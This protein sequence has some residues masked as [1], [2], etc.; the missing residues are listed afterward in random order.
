MKDSHI[1]LGKE[2]EIKRVIPRGYAQSKDFKTKKIF[3]GGLPSSL[4]DGSL[5][6]IVIVI[7]NSCH[8][9]NID[10]YLFIFFFFPNCSDEFKNFF[11]N[12]GKV[13]EHQIKMDHTTNR[14]RCF[15]FIVFDCEQVVDDLLAKG[16]R[17]DLAGRKIIVLQYIIVAIVSTWILAV[18]NSKTALMSSGKYTLQEPFWITIILVTILVSCHNCVEIKKAEPKKALNPPPSAYGSDF[19]A[20]SFGDGA[21]GFGSSYSGF[22]PAQYRGVVSFGSRLGG[23]GGGGH[24]PDAGE[25]GGAYGGFDSHF[26][27]YQGNSSLDYSSHIGSSGGGFPGGYGGSG[28]DGGFVRDEAFDGY[29]SSS[30]G[31]RYGYGSGAGRAG[32]GVPGRYHPYA[33]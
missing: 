17:I 24:G 7:Q 21:G 33:R 13:V 1:I 20:R 18:S 15:G 25:F 32:Y 29:G 26:G 12:Y 5:C 2:V 4:T 8:H 9:K 14:S 31:S 30:Y 23:Y 27:G 19:R 6:D 16:N 10:L 3:V 28:L 11:S 22:G